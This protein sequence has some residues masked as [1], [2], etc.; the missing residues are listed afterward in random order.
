MTIS[1]GPLVSKYRSIRILRFLIQNKI[2]TVEQI[3]NYT[4]NVKRNR[5]YSVLRQMIDE[6]LIIGCGRVKGQGRGGNSPKL[7]KAAEND[8][9][10][11]LI[12]YID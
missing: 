11:E 1:H 6:D 8:K 3:I 5:L 10:K 4:G 2:G 12:G 7:F 9:V